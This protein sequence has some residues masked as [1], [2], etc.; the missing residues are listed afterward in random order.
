M[1]VERLRASG[2]RVRDAVGEISRDLDTYKD[3]IRSSR[4]EF[5]VAK[6]AYVKTHSGWF[7]DRSV[8]YL[9][10]GLPVILQNTGYTDWLP[11]GEGVLAFSSL[12]EAVVCIEKVNSNYT[13]HRRAA[14]EIAERVFSYKVVLPRL[15]G[16]ATQ[17]RPILA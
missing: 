1:T 13:A 11:S 7:S 14:R 10:A 3:Y 6:N 2:W 5:S 12:D 17:K 4:G 16:I 9:A 15:V 8:C